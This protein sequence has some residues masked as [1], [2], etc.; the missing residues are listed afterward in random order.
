MIE[1]A[2]IPPP[3]CRSKSLFSSR[4]SLP[5]ARLKAAFPDRNPGPAGERSRRLT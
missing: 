4:G 5:A 2:M 3:A 1:T